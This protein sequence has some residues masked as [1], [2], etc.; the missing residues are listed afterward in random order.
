MYT[1]QYLFTSKTRIKILDLLLFNNRSYHLRDLARKIR[2]TPIYV[3][4]ELKKLEK[5]NLVHKKKIANLT[6][7]KINNNCKIKEELKIIFKKC[8]GGSK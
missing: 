8:N 1:L 6:L 4:K 5:I 3:S 7:Y 2:I